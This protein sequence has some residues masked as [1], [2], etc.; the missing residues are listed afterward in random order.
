MS[1]EQTSETSN[2]NVSSFPYRMILLVGGLIGLIVGYF[3]SAKLRRIEMNRVLSNEESLASV[4]AL[5][6][7]IKTD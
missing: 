2:D 6:E 4:T 7:A 1:Y 5:K 3:L